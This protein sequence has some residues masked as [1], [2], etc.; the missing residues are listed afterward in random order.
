MNIKQQIESVEREISDLM[1]VVDLRCQRLERLLDGKE[2]VLGVGVGWV[3]WMRCRLIIIFGFG[4]WKQVLLRNGGD[5][6]NN[7]DVKYVKKSY[8]TYNFL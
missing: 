6:E 2:W 8:N 1:F 4:V 7:S 5:Y 3:I